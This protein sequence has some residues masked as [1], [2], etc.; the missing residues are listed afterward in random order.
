[1]LWKHACGVLCC[2][3][4]VWH[5]CELAGMSYGSAATPALT[6]SVSDKPECSELAVWCD[7]KLA[8]CVHSCFVLPND[9]CNVDLCLF[10][11]QHAAV[12]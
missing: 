1:M 10:A 5:G 11:E 6:C 2:L 8:Q 9:A 7:G 3:D 12:M 4:A